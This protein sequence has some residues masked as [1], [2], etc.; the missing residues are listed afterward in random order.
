M[1]FPLHATPDRSNF[2]AAHKAA[3]VASTRL[4]GVSPSQRSSAE[5]FLPDWGVDK[6]TLLG[7]RGHAVPLKHGAL[8]PSC[9]RGRCED[10]TE[11]N[12][13]IQVNGCTGVAGHVVHAGRCVVR[14]DGHDQTAPA[15]SVRLTMD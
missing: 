4:F 6:P 7:P 14:S 15:L 5:R 13:R 1:R 12:R 10:V 9:A 3:G 2:D 11:Q 8:M